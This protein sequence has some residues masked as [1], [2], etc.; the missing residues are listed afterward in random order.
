MTNQDIDAIMAACAAWVQQHHRTTLTHPEANYI[1]GKLKARLHNRMQPKPEELEL[2]TLA[3]RLAN[4]AIAN[5]RDAAQRTE[6]ARMAR[7]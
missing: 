2:V 1:R 6:H 4:S 7:A 3:H 5:R